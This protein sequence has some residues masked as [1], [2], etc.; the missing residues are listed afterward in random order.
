MQDEMKQLLERL[1]L[2]MRR[3]RTYLRVREELATYSER[4]LHDMGM[5]RADI[6]RIAREAAV[7][8]ELADRRQDFFEQQLGKPT[9]H[10]YV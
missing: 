9:P 5:S 2:A 1:S 7:L 3:W 8:S 4:D 6:G 10:P